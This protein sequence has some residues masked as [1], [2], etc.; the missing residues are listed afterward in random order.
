MRSQIKMLN[1]IDLECPIKFSEYDTPEIT[2][3]KFE[4]IK[5]W[6]DEHPEAKE[7]LK[8]WQEETFGS[9]IKEIKKEE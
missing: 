8:K 1:K 5:K 2:K 3:V 7:I 6:Y 4:E 9:I